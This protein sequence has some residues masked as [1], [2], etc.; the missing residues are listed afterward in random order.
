MDPKLESLSLAFVLTLANVGTADGKQA[1]RDAAFSLTFAL[2]DA[3][4]PQDAWA[5]WHWAKGILV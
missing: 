4:Q 3:N 2:L 1:A 5:F